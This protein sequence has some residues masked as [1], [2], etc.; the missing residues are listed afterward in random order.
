[1]LDK[2]DLAKKLEKK[3]YKAIM[4][5]LTEKLGE[6]QRTCREKQIPVMIVFEGWDAAGKGTM[7]N[8]LMLALDARGYK[9]QPTNPPNEE[10]RLRPYMWRFWCKTP[11]HGRITI[12]DRSWYGRV[13]VERVN[14]LVS[15][16]VWRAAY[17]E[18][19]SFERQLADDGTVI[20]K[21]FLH[22]SKKEQKKRFKALEENKAT[23]WKVTRED[24]KNHQRYDEYAEAVEDMLAA[25]DSYQAPWTIVESTDQRHATAK[26][27]GAVIEALQS[28]LDK[29]AEAVPKKAKKTAAEA[30][31]ESILDNVD[32]SQDVDRDEYETELGECQK[33]IFDLE[34]EI[35]K[36]RIP[37]MIVYE[38]WDAA[39]KGGNIRRL[40]QG[41][42]PRGFEVI[43]VAAPNDVEKQHHYLWRFWINMPKAGHIAIFDRSWYGRVMVE[44]IEGFCREDE[45][46]RAFAEIN[47][48]EKQCVD[49]GAVLVKFWLHIDQKEQLK[50]FKGR[51]SLTTKQWKITDEDWRNREKW[52][53]YKTAVDDMLRKTSTNYAPWTIVEANSKLHARLKAIKTVIGAIEDRL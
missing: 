32:L 4:P 48:M 1:M 42:D 19:N 41:M 8:R 5:G 51:E 35:Y 14:K 25:T 6:L 49:F 46:Q 33:R 17:E 24:W 39:G 29:I 16:K 44:R 22:I 43:P 3:Q 15:K 18:I 52:E 38:G 31:H 26:V 27:F 45:W 12:F 34:H 11:A 7:I 9:V 47:E 10:E 20:V 13:L 30:K 21:F 28:R 53:Q 23:S 37:V 50:R 36:K 2:V 40:V